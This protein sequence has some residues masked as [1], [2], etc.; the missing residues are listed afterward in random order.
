M[1]NRKL[2]EAA[3]PEEEV[4]L[5]PDPECASD[6]LWPFTAGGMHQVKCKTCGKIWRKSIAQLTTTRTWTENT[7]HGPKVR[8]ETQPLY[9]RAGSQR[10]EHENR[11]FRNPRKNYTPGAYDD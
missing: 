3:P 9:E 11:G 5:C 6:D 7:V 10:L 4:P 1:P 8:S 2:L